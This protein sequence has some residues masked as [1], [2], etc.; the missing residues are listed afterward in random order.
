[1]AAM[2]SLNDSLGCASLSWELRAAEPPFAGI[3]SLRP[4]TRGRGDPPLV[5]P[6]EPAAYS[7]GRWALCGLS[8]DLAGCSSL[9]RALGYGC[10]YCFACGGEVLQPQRWRVGR[11]VGLELPAPRWAPAPAWGCRGRTRRQPCP[12]S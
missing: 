11:R 3:A 6:T 9:A 4:A 5:L 7:A 10:L 2:A 12:P 8:C 1:M